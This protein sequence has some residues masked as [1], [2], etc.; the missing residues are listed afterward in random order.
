MKRICLLSSEASSISLSNLFCIQMPLYSSYQW[1]RCVKYSVLLTFKLVLCRLLYGMC[2]QVL[3]SAG[4]CCVM[5][6]EVN[7][8]IL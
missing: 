7:L 4:N 2:E 6:N 5:K 8:G 1:Q 3:L